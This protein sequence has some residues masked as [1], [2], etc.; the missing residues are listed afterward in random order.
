M[1]PK[2]ILLEHPIFRIVRVV[3]PKFIDEHFVRG[4][5][6]REQITIVYLTIGKNAYCYRSDKIIDIKPNLT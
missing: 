2:K 5:V 4:A 6:K 3:S 1:I